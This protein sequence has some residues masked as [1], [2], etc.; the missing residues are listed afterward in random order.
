MAVEERWFELAEE[1]IRECI[2]EVDYI[3]PRNCEIPVPGAVCEFKDAH[4]EGSRLVGG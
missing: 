1:T 3:H 4:L 2:G